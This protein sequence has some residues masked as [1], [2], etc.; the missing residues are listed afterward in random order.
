MNIVARWPGSVHDSTIFNNSEIKRRYENNE[1][2]NCIL[3]GKLICI[4]HL[5]YILKCLCLIYIIGSANLFLF[6]P[7]ASH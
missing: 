4:Y 5:T 3:L 6:P 2:P 1:F 7:Q